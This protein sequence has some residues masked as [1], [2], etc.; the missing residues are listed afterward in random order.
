MELPVMRLVAPE[1]MIQE[2]KDVRYV[3]GL[4]K[5][6]DILICLNYNQLFYGTMCRL[7]L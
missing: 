3:L 6:L 2:V 4:L 5:K 1:L 7:E